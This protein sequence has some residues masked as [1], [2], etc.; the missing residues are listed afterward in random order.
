MSEITEL[1]RQTRKNLELASGLIGRAFQTFRITKR[2]NRVVQCQ[3]I[4]RAKIEEGVY[5]VQYF[6]WV[7]GEPGTMEL[8]R[9]E[10]MLKWQFYEDTEHMNFWHKYRY[11]EP[12]DANTTD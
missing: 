10:D 5:L 6:E 9:I 1:K 11:R 4:I 2:G 12:D 7:M 3:G 8:V